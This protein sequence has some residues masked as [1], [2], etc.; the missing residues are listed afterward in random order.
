MASQLLGSPL[1]FLPYLVIASLPLQE[2][3]LV[4][5]HVMMFDIHTK[6][7]CAKAV[8]GKRFQVK[9]V[10]QDLSMSYRCYVKICN[11]G[12][13]SEMKTFHESNICTM[14]T[15][16]LHWEKFKFFSVFMNFQRKSPL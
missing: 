9:I 16:S 8:K 5:G 12:S 4:L 13:G 6:N 14:L 15:Q 1:L 11:T 10:F 7:S 2:G 3:T